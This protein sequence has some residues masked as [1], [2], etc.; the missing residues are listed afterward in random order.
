MPLNDNT[1]EEDLESEKPVYQPI[2]HKPE[3]DYSLIKNI[4]IG[5]GIVAIIVAVIFF[6][7]QQLVKSDTE[8]TRQEISLSDNSINSSVP[9]QSIT[10]RSAPTVDT[11]KQQIKDEI[12]ESVPE[13]TGKQEKPVIAKEEAKEQIHK[14]KPAVEKSGSD[15]GVGRYTIYVASFAEKAGARSKAGEWEENGFDA[16]ILEARGRYRVAIGRFKTEVSA[17]RFVSENREIFGS[18]Y[19]VSKTPK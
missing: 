17:R 7:Y 19:W 4:V 14:E 5:V 3:K 9:D 1:N 2:L 8:I 6:T 18:E 15:D 13:E 11:I 10:E 16:R 12:K